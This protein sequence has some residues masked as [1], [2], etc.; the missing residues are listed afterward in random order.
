MPKQLPT[1]KNDGKPVFARLAKFTHNQFHCS[2]RSPQTNN[3]PSIL[4]G[5]RKTTQIDAPKIVRARVRLAGFP[6]LPPLSSPPPPTS[7]IGV[8]NLIMFIFNHG[9]VPVPLTFMGGGGGFGGGSPSG[10]KFINHRH[11]P[12]ANKQSDNT[13]LMGKST[14]RFT[15]FCVVGS[16]LSCG[17]G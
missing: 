15:F 2:L 4:L 11:A 9:D 8:R 10:G 6:H 17:F 13:R 16:T 12:R 1:S 3:I 7:H 5:Q 14:S